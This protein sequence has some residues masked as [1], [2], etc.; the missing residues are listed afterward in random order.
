MV[1]QINPAKQEPVVTWEKLP[2]DFILPDDPVENIQQP[3]LAAALTDALGTCD[4]RA[5]SAI[6]QLETERR[7]GDRIS[8]G[9]KTDTIK[10]PLSAPSRAL[11]KPIATAGFATC[12]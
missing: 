10:N 5:N 9:T 1:L 11:V 7:S 8:C 2:S 6:A 12:K 4:R 3:L